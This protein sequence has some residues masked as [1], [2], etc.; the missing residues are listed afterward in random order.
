MHNSFRSLLTP[1]LAAAA[2]VVL[3]TGCSP[4]AKKTRYL[5]Q[6]DRYFADGKYDEAEIDYKNVLQLDPQNARAIGQLGFIYYAQGS[7]ARSIPFIYRA[8]QLKP[9]DL[10]LRVKLGLVS[11]AAGKFDQARTQADFVLIRKPDD[12]DA[13]ILLT[14]SAV[15][16]KDAE[17]ARARLTKLPTSAAEQAPVLI[18]LGLLEARRGK[19]KEA[20]GFF[21]R[22]VAQNPKSA[23]AHAALANLYR[24]QGDTAKAEPEYAAAAELS[25]PRSPR[26]LQYAQFK[27][28]SGDL[29]AG[30]AQLN[31]IAKATPDYLPALV[32]LGEIAATEKKYDES[33]AWV[34]KVLTRDAAY[35]EALL[36]SARLKL[37]KND[38]A[39]SVAESEKII[40]IYPQSPQAHFQLAL[41]Q[42]AAGQSDKAMA[43][44]NQVLMLAPGFAD[45]IVLQAGLNLKK[46][47]SSATIAALKQLLSRRPE[48]QQAWFLL[49]DAQR[50]QGNPD[51][52]FVTLTEMN[53][54][55]PRNPQ[56][57]V[58]TGL[59]LVQQRKFK[60]ARASFEQALEYD[61]AFAVAEEQMVYL[62]LNE[63]RVDAGLTR[64]KALSAKYPKVGTYYVLLGRIYIAQRDYNSAESILQK[65]IEISP[66]APEAYY[67]LAGVYEATNQRD[68]AIANLQQIV[69]KKPD[70][71]RALM[72]IGLLVEQKKDYAMAR[73]VY[74]KLLAVDPK[75][76]SAQNNLAYLY[77]EKFNE[78]DKALDAAQKARELAPNEPHV[79]DTLGWVLFKKKQY[80][81]AVA[82][83]QE[84][85]GKLPDS[86][87]VQYHLG[88]ASYM[89]ADEAG[90][91]A[92][93]GRALEI[94]PKFPQADSARTH[95]ATL[96][97]NLQTAPASARSDLEKQLAE[98]PDDPFVLTRLGALYERDGDNDK[99]I[100]SY[101]AALKVNAKNV[102]ATLG[103]IRA[104]TAKQDTPKAMEIA[105]AARKTSPDSA[106]LARAVGHLALQAGDYVWAASLLQDAADKTPDDATLQYD[107]AQAAYA[108][109]RVSDAQTAMKA[110]LDGNLPAAQKGTGKRLL[111]MIAI[112]DTPSAA[113]LPAV[114]SALKS[115]PN[116]V[117]ALVAHAAIDLQKRD[118][119]T[120][121]ANYEK[122][123]AR[124]ANFTPAKRALAIIYAQAPADDAKAF[125]Y[126]TKAREAYPD[127][128]E[129]ARAFGIIAYRRNDFTRAVSLLRESAQDRP[130]DAELLYYLGMSQAKSKSQ[131]G[132][133]D[134]LQRAL[135]LNLKPELAAE[136]KKVLKDLK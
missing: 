39:K 124:Y 58:N 22:A 110:A 31:Q 133:K 105:K 76:M 17:E 87:E 25:P 131:A 121:K 120:A 123:L 10:P 115:D 113:S 70:D 82:L 40:K 30:K 14:E 57:A 112:A 47:N 13:P 36:L 106:E 102:G 122:A 51:D 79:A 24:L 111:D 38:V 103:L 45:A 134:T 100:K 62:D 89:M 60:E 107:L 28:Q 33:A 34:T 53:R 119:A 6:A 81:R 66:D 77:S 99:A 26:K 109:G 5:E 108:I 37:A 27:I 9:E 92:A 97:F 21:T 132:A 95:L 85:A 118:I 65:A 114:D 129:L 48:M 75:F 29:A 91:K 15:T 35:P 135:Q 96:S 23:D 78:L 59:V 69:A 44:L 43:S 90:A 49:S 136:A 98:Y 50:T 42:L 127:D 63:G 1:L 19:T 67:L 74:E 128:V 32:S 18:A 20:E 55:F 88:M 61:P 8:Q 130:D 3:L 83:L 56:I 125:E 46:G 84:S 94:D 80:S 52:A 117:S 71:T 64:A 16:P 7:V 12:P 4:E 41:S 116:D 93:L 73:G 126:A 72:L 54:R 86:A 11:M 101:D 104:Y 68:K 2:F